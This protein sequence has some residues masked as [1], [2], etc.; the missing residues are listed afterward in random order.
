MAEETVTLE[1]VIKAID[2]TQSDQYRASSQPAVNKNTRR[3]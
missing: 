3:Q 2:S 1:A